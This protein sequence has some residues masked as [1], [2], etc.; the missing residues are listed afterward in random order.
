MSA[1]LRL[2]NPAPPAFQGLLRDHFQGLAASPG[3]GSDP[4][5]RWQWEQAAV[6]AVFP[7]T[8]AGSWKTEHD[9]FVAFLLLFNQPKHLSQDPSSAEG[10]QGPDMSPAQ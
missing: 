8:E 3:K 7:M 9:I 6:V 1:V 5:S 4:M 2:G 10:L